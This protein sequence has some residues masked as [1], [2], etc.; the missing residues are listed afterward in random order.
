MEGM[1]GMED[2]EGTEG[3]EG[4]DMDGIERIQTRKRNKL[5]TRKR[6]QLRRFPLRRPCRVRTWVRKNIHIPHSN[7]RP[8]CTTGF[9]DLAGG[10]PGGEGRIGDATVNTQVGRAPGLVVGRAPWLVAGRAAGL[11]VCGAPGLVVGGVSGLG[12]WARPLLVS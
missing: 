2:M 8:G 6:S 12:V 5:R 9:D 1:E 3:T 7:R 10:G 11:V 4:T